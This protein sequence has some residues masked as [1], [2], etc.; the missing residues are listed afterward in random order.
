MED[1]NGMDGHTT[2]Q[3]E[4]YHPIAW[5]CYTWVEP[6]TWKQLNFLCSPDGQDKEG[7]HLDFFN[8]RNGGTVLH[9]E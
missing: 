6:L 2:M 5:L 4:Q 7:H 1:E 3:P 9:A 8:I